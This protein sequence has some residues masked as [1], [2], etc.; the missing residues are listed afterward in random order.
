[1][2]KWMNNE[3]TKYI[4]TKQMTG[5]K[6]SVGFIGPIDVNNDVNLF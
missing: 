4:R 6:I 3:Y 1:M 2:V 5:K